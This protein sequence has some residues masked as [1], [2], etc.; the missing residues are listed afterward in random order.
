MQI[1]E[2]QK[3]ETKG[4]RVPEIG[5]AARGGRGRGV[6]LGYDGAYRYPELYLY[7]KYAE[8][9]PVSCMRVNGDS[10]TGALIS[11]VDITDPNTEFSS[12]AE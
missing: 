9:S 3:V 12:A 1:A 11:E 7:G 5:K 10:G 6:E 4:G 8:Y 2:R